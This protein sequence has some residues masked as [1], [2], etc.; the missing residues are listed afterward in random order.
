MTDDNDQ[1]S[2]IKKITPAE[3]DSKKEEVALDSSQTEKEKLKNQIQE[4]RFLWI[5]AFIII[6]DAFIFTLMTNWGGPIAILI[7]E[8]IVILMLAKKFN[9]KELHNLLEKLLAF[10][11]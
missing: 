3:T 10:K 6:F 4:E 8:I 5:I 11:K 9:V 7:L 1:S 2:F